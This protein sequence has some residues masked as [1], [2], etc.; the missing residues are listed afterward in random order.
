MPLF[1]DVTLY[2]VSRDLRFKPFA[3]ELPRFYLTSWR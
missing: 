1:T 2:A 3:D